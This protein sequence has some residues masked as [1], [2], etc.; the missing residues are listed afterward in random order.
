MLISKKSRL[1]ECSRF[2]RTFA[3]GGLCAIASSSAFAQEL[4][5]VEQVQAGGWI[6]L[7]LLV[8]SVVA[9]AIA[10]ERFLR[11]SLNVIAPKGL[12][13]KVLSLWKTENFSELESM[14][15]KENSTLGRALLFMV[16][17][18]SHGR[19]TVSTGTGDISSMELRHH[20]QKA[21]PLAVVATIAPILGLLGTVVGM[22]EAFHVVAYSGEIGDPALL[23]DGIS[24]ALT[25][26]AAGL[27]VAL[28]ALG[29]HHYF[30]SRVVFYGLILEK[31]I[32]DL[33]SEVFSSPVQ[34]QA[35]PQPSMQGA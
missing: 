2:T 5:L 20:Q 22:I 29:L 24:K 31:N 8:L 34:A 18:R 23:A 15:A 21:Y 1:F 16:T 7:V 10:I 19:D 9:V 12:S 6:V 3:V 32:N 25:T 26:T 33:L 28:P 4:D 14:L 13:E 11:F 17:H 35:R 27:I 30:K